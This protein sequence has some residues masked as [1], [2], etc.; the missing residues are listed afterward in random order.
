MLVR[1][2]QSSGRRPVQLV[3]EIEVL[4][5]DVD[6]GCDVVEADVG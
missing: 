3:V 2:G 6:A 5:V 1:E 4:I